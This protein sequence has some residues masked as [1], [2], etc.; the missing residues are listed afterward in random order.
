MAHVTKVW[1]KL[2]ARFMA[3]VEPTGF[4]VMGNPN[5][6]VRAALSDDPPVYLRPFGGFAR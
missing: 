5:D 2:G 3:A 1:A 4:T 6:A